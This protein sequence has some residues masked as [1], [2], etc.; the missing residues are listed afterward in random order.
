MRKISLQVLADAIGED[1][2]LHGDGTLETLNISFSRI[3]Q[4]FFF[5]NDVEKIAIPTEVNNKSNFTEKV[6]NTVLKYTSSKPDTNHDNNLHDNDKYLKLLSAY[7]FTFISELRY[8]SYLNKN[9]TISR[10]LQYSGIRNIELLI[11]VPISR[12]HILLASKRDATQLIEAI[13]SL[14]LRFFNDSDYIRPSDYEIYKR[15]LQ[16]KIID[17]EEDLNKGELYE[18]PEILK[19]TQAQLQELKRE[20]ENLEIMNNKASSAGRLLKF[21]I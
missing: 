17:Y 5:E 2:Y 21:K 3:E 16:M 9:L 6:K 7:R 1:I 20:L 10:M 19:A 13:H 14:G 12:L 15:V 11:L 8:G 4:L 18:F